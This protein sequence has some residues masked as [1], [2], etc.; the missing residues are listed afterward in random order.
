VSADDHAGGLSVPALLA[1]NLIVETVFN[2]NGLGL[3]F[4]TRL[5]EADYPVLLAYTLMGAILTVLGN[6]AADIALT[7]ADPRLRLVSRRR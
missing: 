7:E 2:Y 3:T 5:Q 1:G 4:F 6:L